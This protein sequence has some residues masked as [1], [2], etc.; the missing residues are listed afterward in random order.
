M[1]ALAHTK[2]RRVTAVLLVQPLQQRQGAIVRTLGSSNRSTT[3][4]V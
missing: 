4:T 3:T 1:D 2:K